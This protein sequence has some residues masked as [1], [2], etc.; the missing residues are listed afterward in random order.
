MENDVRGAMNDEEVYRSS[1]PA[2]RSSFL[3]NHPHPNPLPETCGQQY[4]ARGPEGEMQF[5]LAAMIDAASAKRDLAVAGGAIAPAVADELFALLV[6]SS[7]GVVNTLCL[8]RT[9]PSSATPPLALAVFDALSRNQ[10]VPLGEVT[11]LQV[12][13]RIVP[14]SGDEEL[15]QLQQR[16]I[17]LAS[18]RST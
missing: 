10:P 11:R 3:P 16:M 8:S 9:S 15:A 1:F 4:R 6:K 14:G 5:A 18:G 7:A 12:L 2:H 17:A 13:S